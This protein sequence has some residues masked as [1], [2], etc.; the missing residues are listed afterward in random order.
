M[1]GGPL[2]NLWRYLRGVPRGVGVEYGNCA[3]WTGKGLEQAGVLPRF[4]IWPKALWVS[5]YNHVD[6]D[7]VS[8]CYYHAAE[9]SE[10]PGRSPLVS[11]GPIAPFR[12][13]M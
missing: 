11:F 1:Q 9:G 7:N 8:V 10:A 3:R 6:T 12:Y 4:L 5:I 2:S 13:G